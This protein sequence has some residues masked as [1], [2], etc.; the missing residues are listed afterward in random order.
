MHNA[1]P[2]SDGDRMRKHSDSSSD[3]PPPIPDHEMLRCI[4]RGSYGEVWLAKSVMGTFRAVK[5]V[6]RNRFDEARPFERELSGIQKFEPIS[7]SHDGLVDIL[8]VGRNDKAGYFY[9]VMELADDASQPAGSLSPNPESYVPRT[10]GHEFSSRGRLPPEECLPLFVSLASGLSHLHQHGLIHRDIKPSNLMLTRTGTIK[11]IDM[12][13]A[14]T[15][16]DSAMQLTQTGLVLGTVTYCAPE[17]FRDASRVDI[18]ADIYSLGCTLYH[19]LTGK[20]PYRERKTFAEVVQAHL[21]E[22][23][24]T[25]AAVRPDAPAGLETVLARMTAKDPASRFAT[26]SAVAEALEPFAQGADLAPLVPASVP[27]SP[28][29]RPAGAKATPAPNQ[30]HSASNE[31]QPKAHWSRRAALVT[32]PAAAGAVFLYLNYGKRNRVVLTDGLAVPVGT[33]VVFLV[34]TVVPQGIYDEEDKPPRGNANADVLRTV[35]S[36]LKRPVN[37]P[38]VLIPGDWIKMGWDGVARVIIEDP[39]LLLIHRSSFFHPANA[40]IGLGY[41]PFFTT[42]I[43]DTSA[44]G[45]GGQVT[46]AV[47]IGTNALAFTSWKGLYDA[48]DVVLVGFLANI[49]AAAKRCRFLVYSRGTDENWKQADFRKEWV[50]LVEKRHSVLKGRVTAMLI[51]PDAAGGRGSFRDPKTAKSILDWV[52]DHLPPSE[53]AK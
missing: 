30:R 29:P 45:P 21:N 38:S 10:L 39:D 28:P 33:P 17:Q 25:L 5:L 49:A 42:N 51:E 7:R 14:L 41:P 27:Q 50:E 4:G 8:Q 1:V 16:E 47:T 12:G 19:L 15:K 11:V 37:T 20:A 2:A 43:V 22:P 48:C 13:L 34:D 46:N 6:Y 3:S 18:R 53:K 52:T 31:Q 26:P 23:F 32:L 9:Y 40:I 35:L 36:K 24:P 44:L